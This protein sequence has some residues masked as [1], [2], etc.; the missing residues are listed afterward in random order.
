MV[1]RKS[2]KLQVVGSSPAPAISL[3]PRMRLGDDVFWIEP[4]R[5]FRALNAVWGGALSVPIL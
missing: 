3:A 1:A 2:H 5:L 4:L